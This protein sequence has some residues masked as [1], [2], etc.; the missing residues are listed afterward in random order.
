MESAAKVKEAVREEHTSDAGRV[1]YLP[2]AAMAL[3][4]GVGSLAIAI[5]GL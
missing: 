5:Q 3:R 1:S 2:E 4:D